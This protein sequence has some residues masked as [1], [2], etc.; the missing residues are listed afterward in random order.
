[1]KRLNFEQRPAE[2]SSMNK[3]DPFFVL[4]IVLL[5]ALT[6][7]FNTAQLDLGD[8][9]LLAVENRQLKTQIKLLELKQQDLEL[10]TVGK[11]SLA[12]QRKVASVDAAPEM[13]RG[14]LAE[15]LYQEVVE[16]CI[17]RKK[18]LPCLDKIDAIVTQ[19]PESKWA[20]KSLV[21][22]TGRYIKEKRNE[23]AADLVKIVRQEF[24]NEA[25][26]QKLL[27][28]VEKTQL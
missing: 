9:R 18:D 14:K 28:E 3:V 6:V 11:V 5:S 27:Q 20:G 8:S 2:K 15:G 16:Q 24:K 22:L 4:M 13:D 25:E 12:P 26:V 23:Q 10:G 1:M 19:F 7:V 21:V 17:K